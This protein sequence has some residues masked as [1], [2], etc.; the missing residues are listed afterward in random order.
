[1]QELEIDAVRVALGQAVMA[2]LDA[3]SVPRAVQR[4]LLALSADEW[5]RVQK[6][7]PL[8]L[9]FEV[10]ERA[11]HLQALAARHD[12]H[13]WTASVPGLLDGGLA[14]LAAAAQHESDEA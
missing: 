4:E 11:G 12:D 9:Q 10:L 8:P 6:G 3:R 2:A 13:W 1:M 14:A 5:A 7:A